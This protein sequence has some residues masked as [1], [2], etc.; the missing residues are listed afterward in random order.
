MQQLNHQEDTAALKEAARIAASTAREK[1]FQLPH[2]E[3]MS[4]IG[5]K[6]ECQFL[7]STTHST[8][9]PIKFLGRANIA[10]QC[11]ETQ[12]G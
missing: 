11:F 10:A 3:S 5:H 2:A 7:S 1:K 6:I 12:R 8:L 4:V 9:A